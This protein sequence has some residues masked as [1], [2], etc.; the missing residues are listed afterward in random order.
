MGNVIAGVHKSALTLRM[1]VKMLAWIRFV[2]ILPWPLAFALGVR[3]SPPHLWLALL[4][5]GLQAGWALVYGGRAL[6]TGSLPDWLMA[7]DIA[8]TCSCLVVSGLGWSTASG[9]VLAGMAVY[10]AV[11]VA[12]ATGVVWWRGRAIAAAILIAACYV[13]GILPEFHS[14]A[15]VIVTVIG[16][17]LSLLGFTVV[18]GVI[19]KRLL[20]QAETIAATTAAMLSAR[21]HA[22]AQHARHD[23]R[24]TQ[25]RLLHDTV[26]STLNTIAR[27]DVQVSAQLR[28]RCAAEAD[29][30]R[31]MISGDGRPA[32]PLIAELALVVRHQAALGLRVHSNI[33]E[34]PQ[35]L[36]PKATVALV[37]SCREALN[38]VAKHAGTDEAWLTACAGQDGSVVISVVDRGLGF[39]PELIAGGLGMSQSIVARMAEA[40]G[41]SKVDSGSG[42]GTCVELRW[43]RLSAWA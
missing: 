29:A 31:S 10:P 9:S 22:A 36:P 21:E 41:T 7:L 24:M 42:E 3:F 37:G 4:G 38:N 11:G 14:G 8:V 32:T 28:Q 40:G 15:P 5:Y 27:G 30:L 35:A 6:R 13:I 18:A 17:V 23:E 34:L 12:L 16:N 43:P 25:Y 20:G 19:T 2:Q 26:L 39:D 1:L 33:G